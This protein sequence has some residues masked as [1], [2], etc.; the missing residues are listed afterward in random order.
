MSN[1]YNVYAHPQR[2][3]WGFARLRPSGEVKT[4][5][6]DNER[7]ATLATLSPLKFA[8]AL[9]QRLRAGFKKDG[10]PRY[11]H[12]YDKSG[13]MHGDFVVEHPDLAPH[14]AGQ[15]VFF[16]KLPL[17]T[18]MKGVVSGWRERLDEQAGNGLERD[19]WL[20]LCE[21]ATAYVPVKTGDVHAALVAAQWA[22]ENNLVLVSSTGELPD[23]TPQEQRHEWRHFL[24]VSFPQA[25]V[26]RALADFGWPLNEALGPVAPVQTPTRP[27]NDEGWLTLAQQASF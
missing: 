10:H 15:M 24:A 22:K 6:I 12:C 14:L 21:R 11:F 18:E 13:V 8:P 27:A 2:G 17:G 3:W 7:R 1:V 26:D 25:A 9:Q 16:V 5:S 20:H 23:R 19:Q 4:A